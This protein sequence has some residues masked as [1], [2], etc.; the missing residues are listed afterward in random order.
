M[1]G[2]QPRFVSEMATAL[3][4]EPQYGM[5]W[6]ALSTVALAAE[7]LG[8]GTFLRSDHYTAF[9]GIARP[10]TDAWATLAGLAPLTTTIR[11]G[12]LVSPVTFRYPG[13]LAKVAATV[14]EMSDGRVD[15]GLGTGWYEPEHARHG[16][17]FPDARARR[18]MLAEGLAVIRTLW[19]PDG[20]SLE[21]ERWPVRDTQFHPKPR[22]RL[23]LGG[24]GGP[25]SLALA[26]EWADEYNVYDLGTDGVADVWTRLRA[27]CQAIGRD[28]ATIS[29]SVMAVTVLGSGS[30]LRERIGN[31]RRVLP[32][33]GDDDEVVARG[34]ST[35]LVG[36]GD[37]IVD[38]VAALRRTGASKIVFQDMTAD[39]L[40]MVEDL[41]RQVLPRI[42]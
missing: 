39:D 8:F 35:W 32:D 13:E 7:R 14:D 38:R 2:R 16:L 21:G 28:P 23:V 6:S 4:V 25:K 30:D 1:S 11:L 17:P 18:E 20:A 41:A 19:G 24:N 42:A 22:A 15:L 31:L 27:A 5:S 9:D 3:M 26:A 12:T 10:S 37:A 29:L 33:V 34:R 36:D 40:S